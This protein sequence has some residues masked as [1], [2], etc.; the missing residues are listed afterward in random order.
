MVELPHKNTHSLIG[1]E[2]MPCNNSKFFSLMSHG[3]LLTGKTPNMH[4]HQKARRL[5]A[6]LGYTK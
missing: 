3:I 4:I 6:V 5:I 1:S 2:V